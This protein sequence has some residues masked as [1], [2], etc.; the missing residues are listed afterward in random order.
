MSHVLDDEQQPR[1]LTLGRLGWTLR[2]I[3]AAT[4]VRRETASGYLRAAGIARD[5][6]C[7]RI[8]NGQITW[9]QNANTQL[10]EDKAALQTSLDAANASVITLTAQVAT[11]TSDKDGPDRAGGVA[12]E[13]TRG[14]GD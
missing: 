14:A 10:G 13:H 4:G 2:R 6:V 3:E 5:G 12:A 11:L 7:P 1:I 8:L 9:L